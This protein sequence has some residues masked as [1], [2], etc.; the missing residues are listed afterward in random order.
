M[1]IEEEEKKYR[2]LYVYM[3]NGKAN[4][5][6]DAPAHTY[7]KTFVTLLYPHRIR[8]NRKMWLL[9]IAHAMFLGNH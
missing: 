5:M 1:E 4:H 6:L 9:K 2:K 8:C 3:G 7:T